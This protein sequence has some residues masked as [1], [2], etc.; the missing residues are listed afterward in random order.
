M[1][2][3]FEKVTTEWLPFSEIVTPEANVKYTIQNRGADIL[4]LLEASSLPD[5]DVEDGVLVQP[6]V[7]AFYVK[8]EQNLYLRAF[9]KNCAVNVTAGE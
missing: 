3:D 4:V 1:Q 5:N 6:Y 7:Q 8:G 2:I 9:S